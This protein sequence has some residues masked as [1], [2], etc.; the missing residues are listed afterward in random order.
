MEHGKGLI[1]PIHSADFPYFSNVQQQ[2]NGIYVSRGLK[3]N[4]NEDGNDAKSTKCP[5]KPHSK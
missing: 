1:F 2:K 5:K 4:G 3:M